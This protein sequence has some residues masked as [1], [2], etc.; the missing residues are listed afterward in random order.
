MTRPSIL[1]RLTMALAVVVLVGTVM[2]GEAG[3]VPSPTPPHIVATPN[4]VMVNTI[5]HLV[6]TGFP[7][8]TQLTIAE[9]GRTNWVVG[10]QQPCNTD[11]TISVVTNRRGRF[12]AQF[13]AEVCPDSVPPTPPVTRRTCYI[14][15]PQPRGVDTITLVGAAKIIVTYP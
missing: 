4:N 11:N 7:V 14:G 15:N 3:A 13:K 12:A 6:G 5:I 2:A 10:A 8:R 1:S 9:C